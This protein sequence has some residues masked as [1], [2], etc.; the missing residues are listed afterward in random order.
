MLRNLLATGSGVEALHTYRK[1]MFGSET[2]VKYVIKSNER[3]SV[4]VVR[5]LVNN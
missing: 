4:E 2:C 3:F 5:F 1:E